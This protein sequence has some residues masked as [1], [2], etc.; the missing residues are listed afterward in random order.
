M[1][2][3]YKKTEAGRMKLDYERPLMA[4]AYLAQS[5]AQNDI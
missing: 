1:Q 3:S 2:G 4:Y 5:G